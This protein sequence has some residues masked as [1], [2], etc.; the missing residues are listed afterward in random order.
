MTTLHNPID[1]HALGQLARRLQEQK[2]YRPVWQQLLQP[3]VLSRFDDF[4]L[5]P[6]SILA[7]C[8]DEH[9][10]ALATRFP[11]A[12]I[13]VLNICSMSPDFL[14]DQEQTFDLVYSHFCLHR[15]IDVSAILKSCL[16]VLKSDGFLFLSFPGPDTLC[17][18][19]AAW[20]QVDDDDHVN[21]FFDMHDVADA[22]RALGG[23]DVVAHREN[24]MMHYARFIDIAR[25]LHVAADSCLSANRRRGLMGRDTWQRA[26][27]AYRPLESGYYPVTIELVVLCARGLKSKEQAISVDA[28]RD[29]L[30]QR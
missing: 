8:D 17:E 27:Q 5:Q 22:V 7:L 16:R 23:R 28:L 18:M 24:M 13:T 26:E 30:R 15:W 2:L 10:P 3:A 19:R 9:V 21:A 1:E 14:S 25:D 6:K 11:G 12:K 20:Q 4:N 29:Q